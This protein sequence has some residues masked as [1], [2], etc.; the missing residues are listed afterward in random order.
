MDDF[1]H[2]YGT[3]IKT[4]NEQAL[5]DVST[6]KALLTLHLPAQRKNAKQETDKNCIALKISC[7]Q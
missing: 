4:N 1:F 6:K 5:C 3:N 2:P 7:F